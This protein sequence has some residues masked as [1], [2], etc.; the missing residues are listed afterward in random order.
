[1]VDTKTTLSYFLGP[2]SIGMEWMNE[3]FILLSDG[4]YFYEWEWNLLYRGTMIIICLS[5]SRTVGN[6]S[7]NIKVIYFAVLLADF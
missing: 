2:T 7:Q 4:S 1:M 6:F 5:Y 3:W